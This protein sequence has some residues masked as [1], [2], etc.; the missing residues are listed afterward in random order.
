MK[1]LFKLFLVLLFASLAAAP[2]ELVNAAGPNQVRLTA[3][4]VSSAAD[5]EAAIIQATRGGSRP[6]VVILDGRLGPFIYETGEGAD[7][8][9]NIFYSNLTLLGENRAELSNSDG[10]FF[11]DLP[12]D[13][14]TIKDLQLVC[15]ADCIVAWGKH[16]QI[17]LQ[18]LHLEAAGF[19]I[20][21]AQTTSWLIQNNTIQ[22]GGTAIHLLE[23]VRFNIQR[24]KLFATTGVLL[25]N[26]AHNLVKNNIIQAS[27]QGVLVASPSNNNQ[28][29]N[30]VI[31][32]V[33]AAGI[34]L[35]PGTYGNRVFRNRVSCAAGAACL[36]VDA[37]GAAWTDNL[38][39]NNDP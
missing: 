36:T 11:D 33:E 4:Q 17:K 19:G 37:P 20:Q 24:N 15:T 9:I 29:A 27:Y 23:A 13:R 8:T 35:E 5:I 1:T 32:G 16:R 31:C 2:T 22:A 10:I 38:I 30:N 14:V 25:E 39:F 6:G 28:V 34:A 18:N 12:A 26:A 21:A 3:D 7:L